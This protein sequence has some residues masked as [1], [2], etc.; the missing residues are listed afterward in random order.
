[1]FRMASPDET[2]RRV[3]GVRERAGS[4]VDALEF[5]V[6]LQAVLVTDDAEAKAA[7]LATVFAHT[8]LDTARRVLDSPYVLVGTAEENARK[9]LANRERYGFGY[10]T[11][12]GPGRDALAEVIP[13]ARRLAEES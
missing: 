8:G 6:L 10:V 12:H 3:D 9:L 11:T 13:H 4:R 2:L 5:N 1:M 7:E